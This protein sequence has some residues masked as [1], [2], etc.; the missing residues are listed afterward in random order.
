M[1]VKKS[2]MED[3]EEPPRYGK[4]YLE[5]HGLASSPHDN[6]HTGWAKPPESTPAPE[7]GDPPNATSQQTL[8]ERACGTE[9]QV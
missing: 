3:S 9:Y 2:R 6:A 5:L 1:V 8:T 7:E 4:N